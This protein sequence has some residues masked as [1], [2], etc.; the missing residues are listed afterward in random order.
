MK[1]HI[2]LYIYTFCFRDMQEVVSFFS[3]Y[4]YVIYHTHVFFIVMLIG[5]GNNRPSLRLI[6]VSY[7]CIYVCMYVCMMTEIS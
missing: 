1:F 5:E 2:L 7:V 6:L 3:L 4:I